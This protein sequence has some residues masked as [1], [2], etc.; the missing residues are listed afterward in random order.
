MLRQVLRALLIILVLGSLVGMAATDR[1]QNERCME[2]SEMTKFYGCQGTDMKYTE[3]TVNGQ[4]V[5]MNY[6]T[7]PESSDAFFLDVVYTV[8][9]D[10]MREFREAKIPL[11]FD[12]WPQHRQLANAIEIQLSDVT[13]GENFSQIKNLVVTRQTM[14][15]KLR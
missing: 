9:V 14:V 13:K 7:E 11:E 1:G 10:G 2:I 15:A 3:T 5:S 4:R 12:T 6:Y 8:R